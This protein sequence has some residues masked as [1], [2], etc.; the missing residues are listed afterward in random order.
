M[1]KIFALLLSL[2]ACG[3]DSPDSKGNV[4]DSNVASEKTQEEIDAEMVDSAKA[5]LIGDWTYPGI[6]IEQL[7]FGEDGTGTYA[8]IGGK[9]DKSYTF[10]YVVYVEHKTYGNGE[11]Y[12]ENTM[13]I[14]Y[15]TGESEIIV[16]EFKEEGGYQK[17]VFRT[18]EGGG[19]SGIM[20]FPDWVK[21]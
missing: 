8:G 5:Q 10:T 21:E 15:H 7:H 16:F 4:S 12:I 3:R 17:M 9:K 13:K 19:Y 6:D 18:T 1:K 14:D 2:A 11:E 20:N